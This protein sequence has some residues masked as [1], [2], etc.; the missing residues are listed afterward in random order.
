MPYALRIYVRMV[1]DAVEAFGRAWLLS[2][3][4]GELL[5]PVCAACKA[6]HCLGA[7]QS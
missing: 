4:Q 6:M 7:L 5:K 3:P 1:E 2:P